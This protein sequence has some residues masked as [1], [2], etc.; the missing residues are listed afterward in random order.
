MNKNG[1]LKSPPCP[2]IGLFLFLF[3]LAPSSVHAHGP[4]T[5]SSKGARSEWHLAEARRS[6]AQARKTK[7]E[8]KAAIGH[9]LD[10]ANEALQSVAVSPHQEDSREAREIYNSAS[11]EVALL[12]KSSPGRWDH[13]QTYESSDEIYQLSFTPGSRVTG[14]WDPD[15]FSFF[16][17]R[18]QVHEK[19]PHLQGDKG[20]WGGVFV[21]V[22]RPPHPR[23]QFLPSAGLA[24][25]I[26]SAL[27]FS[28]PHSDGKRV[29][30]VTLTLYD[31]TRVEMVE[32]SGARRPLAS[33]FHAPLAY[34]RTSSWIGL[35]AMMRPD[36]YKEEQGLYMVEPYDPDRIPVVLV[37]G[38]LSI[39]E[40]W[41]PTISAIESDPVLRGRYQFWVF[42]YP[43]GEPISLSALTLRESLA[44]IYELYPNTRNAILVSHSL[45]GLISQ[46]QVV[47]TG[48]ALWDAVLRSSA[49]RLYAKLPPNHLFKRAL[50]FDANPRVER[51][52]FIC[53]PHRGSILAV[54]L[55]GIIGASLIRLPVHF[56]KI[57]RTVVVDSVKVALGRESFFFPPSVRGLSPRSTLLRALDTLP[58]QVPYHSIIG[59]RGRGDTPNSSDGVVAYWSSHLA[60]AQSELVVPGSHGAFDLPQTVLELKRILHQHL[61]VAGR[62]QKNGLAGA[63]SVHKAA[64]TPTSGQLMAQGPGGENPSAR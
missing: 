55:P 48:R 37:H 34:Y 41:A 60:G 16:R 13:N 25:P 59:D 18:K 38:L 61:K 53:V 56:V 30:E 28:P 6:L 4:V 44:Q 47:S 57:L 36:T 49:N 58:I 7:P 26:T 10:A 5:V 1:Y 15:Y 43:T 21:G 17:T 2:V 12:L 51:I 19:I 32:I 11:E 23:K 3:Y 14:S 46:M 35:L 45:G 63:L 27:S 54:T 39:P 40:M 42:G 50:I 33:D 22:Y 62:S 9:Y 64:G 24:V 20:E 8:V 31:P 29:R 52:T